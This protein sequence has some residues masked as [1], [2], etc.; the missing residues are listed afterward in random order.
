[1][2][3][4]GGQWSDTLFFCIINALLFFVQYVNF[5]LMDC[6]MCFFL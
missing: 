5:E 1:M 2:I 4:R 6:I 3:F